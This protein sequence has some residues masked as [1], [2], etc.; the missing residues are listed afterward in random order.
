MDESGWVRLPLQMCSDLSPS[1]KQKSQLSYLNS[2]GPS[3][4][5]VSKLVWHYFSYPYQDISTI[6]LHISLFIRPRSLQAQFCFV[7]FCFLIIFFLSFH[8]CCAG[9]SLKHAVFPS[10]NMWALIALQPVGDL[11]SLKRDPTHVP[12]PGRQILYHWTNG[13]DPKHSFDPSAFPQI[14]EQYMHLIIFLFIQWSELCVHLQ[15][16]CH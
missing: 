15:W 11:S 13:G 6:Y 1:F 10:C 16:Q 3:Q 2:I 12:W 4:I 7:L 9:S 8:F 5:I 14:L